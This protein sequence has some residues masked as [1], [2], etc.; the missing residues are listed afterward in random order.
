MFLAA[1]SGSLL[2]GALSA[3]ESIGESPS[4][5]LDLRPPG[6]NE[7][8][9][10]IGES[11]FFELDLLPPF[12]NPS[13]ES[14]GESAA[15]VLNLSEANEQTLLPSTDFPE[16]YG[17]E[18]GGPSGI[19][20]S[21]R[22]IF[23]EV[24]LD[25]SERYYAEITLDTAS[26]TLR[27]RFG[28][29]VKK[30][31]W[32]IEV[33]SSKKEM[34]LDDDTVVGLKRVSE[35]VGSGLAWPDSSEDYETAWGLSDWPAAK[36][37]YVVFRE[38]AGGEDVEVA[39]GTFR[40][41]QL[42]SR[43]TTAFDTKPVVL[44]HGL[45]SNAY[46]FADDT[47]IADEDPSN[48]FSGDLS[49]SGIMVASRPTYTLEF[50]NIASVSENAELVED[51]LR[52]IAAIE[53][54]DS[55]DIIAHNMGG[56]LVRYLQQFV[57]AENAS[58]IHR[59]IA[60]GVPFEGSIHKSDASGGARE[61]AYFS[62]FA[63]LL[64]SG[65]PRV[66]FS[67]SA[68]A[69]SVASMELVDPQASLDSLWLNSS[70]E[71]TSDADY[72]AIL[73]VNPFAL[74]LEP[75][76]LL[77]GL[78]ST[79]FVRYLSVGLSLQ[80]EAMEKGL[81]TGGGSDGLT[82]W[83]SGG[84]HAAE[85]PN[86]F[87]NVYVHS[88]QGSYNS[89]LNADRS[90]MITAILGF[91]TVGDGNAFSHGSYV[92]QPDIDEDAVVRVTDGSQKIVQIRSEL[93]EPV[94]DAVVAVYNEERGVATL[95]STMSDDA[96]ELR[97]P[98]GLFIPEGSSRLIALAVGFEMDVDFS[99]ASQVGAD[100]GQRKF[101]EV[102]G[103]VSIPNV[104]TVYPDDDYDGPIKQSVLI[105]K[106]EVT[107]SS[108]TVDLEIS[109]KNASEMSFIGI[110]DTLEWLPYATKATYSFIDDLPGEKSIGVAFRSSSETVGATAVD[111]IFYSP[112]FVESGT[113][114]VSD[115]VGGSSIVLNG[116]VLEKKTPST[117]RGLPPGDYTVTI[118][119]SGVSYEA[120][121][122]TATVTDNEASEVV[123]RRAA[124]TEQA[125]FLT[126]LAQYFSEE[127]LAD[128]SLAGESAD[129]DMDGQAN[130]YEFVA[131]VDPTDRSSLVEVYYVDDSREFMRVSPIVS[132]LNYDIQYT[133][134]FDNWSSVGSELQEV[135]EDEIQI[136]LRGMPEGRYYRVVISNEAS[137]D[138]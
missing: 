12:S 113:L 56:V 3:A 94:S 121:T 117:L 132:G 52:A 72:L 115:H 104:F 35:A 74:E 32:R 96:G 2:S 119:Q 53:G 29:G 112:D 99:S 129:P 136:D 23:P 93:G 101:A 62:L 70:A 106:G 54:T 68:A 7:F 1:F 120:A 100:S 14:V 114:E 33:D 84:K 44:L 6:S 22:V 107:T 138:Q 5:A 8:A 64:A 118:Y 37:E 36:Y 25:P 73:G 19:S 42:K 86:S 82:S 92:T 78:K 75:A 41:G 58:L 105:D 26:T 21:L 95:I 9:E 40:L 59:F 34:L 13:A 81:L 109:A 65:I 71:V 28:S 46:F 4:F 15:F 102:S 60:L 97:M 49:I 130:R 20:F 122:Q 128:A 55:V 16:A 61:M 30:D 125:E 87:K 135:I 89:D 17:G 48:D 38:S 27:P 69:D 103:E 134:G 91:L 85:S 133:E 45:G 39:E 43:N 110:G 79:S 137:S 131:R 18:L 90:A 83:T 57:L 111:T 76:A 67:Q 123:F 126:W 50:P 116:S 31:G 124:E 66:D 63:G 80:A 77:E 24:E 51:A 47:L 11:A 127:E 10:S 98:S 88:N 108:L